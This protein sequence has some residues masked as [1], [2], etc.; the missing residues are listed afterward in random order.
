MTVWR[1]RWTVKGVYGGVQM[2]AADAM[3]IEGALASHGFGGLSVRDSG[4]VV[5][6]SAGLPDTE[7]ARSALMA[8]FDAWSDELSERPGDGLAG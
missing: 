4:G 5:S 3:E 8:T 7:E 1:A 2:R 6:L